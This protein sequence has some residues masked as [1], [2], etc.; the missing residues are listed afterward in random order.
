MKKIETESESSQRRVA[1]FFLLRRSRA[2]DVGLSVVGIFYLIAL[3]ADF[4]AP[5]D[6]RVQSRREPL[7][8]PAALHLCGMRLCLYAQRLIDPLERRY[9]TDTGQS[10]SLSFFTRGYSYRLFGVIATNVH[11]FG[12]RSE[13]VNAPQAHLLGTDAFGRDRLARLLIASRFSLVVGPV[14]LVL[15][16]SLGVLIGCLA[17][18]G[19]RWMD[20]VLMRVADVLLA[21]PTLLLALATRA[22]F[23]PELPPRRAAILLITIFVALGW[24]ELA[25]LTR[26]LVLELRQREFVLGA[27]SLGATP[28]RVLSRHILPNAARPL[29]VQAL[30]LLPTFLLT[31]TSLSFLGVGVQEP[32][33]SW[34]TLLAAV[35]DMALL[36]RG[37][38]LA[39]L[40]P[41]FAIMFFVGSVRLLSQGLQQAD[42]QAER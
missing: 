13:D 40:A 17:G 33:A 34:G 7:A 22:A 31:E 21:L 11:L 3:F 30:L 25:R 6:Y 38:I 15:A 29:V 18:Y 5:Y 2:S 39:L 12:V 35:A 23:P 41:A 37:D 8:P 20:A 36:Q 27:I 24:A 28:W 4:L 26:G 1:R 9:A 16:S 42:E 14:A 32:G 19:A 10:Y